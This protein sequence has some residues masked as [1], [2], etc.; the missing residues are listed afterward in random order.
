MESNA[1]TVEERSPALAVIR[2]TAGSQS[3]LAA[4]A[5]TDIFFSLASNGGSFGLGCMAGR[6]IVGTPAAGA[7]N[8]DQLYLAAND[9]GN[10][11]LLFRRPDGAGGTI[12]RASI[13]VVPPTPLVNNAPVARAGAD[14]QITEGAIFSLNGSASSDSD[15]YPL[16]FQWARTDAGSPGDFFVGSAEQTKPNPQ[17]QAPSLGA[18]PTPLTLTN[19]V[20]MQ[21]FSV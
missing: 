1:T 12:I 10:V 19:P 20:P 15:G 17:L 3:T 14:L 6:G 9:N 21:V 18:D 8:G 16:R 11:M 2:I 4:Q 13:L 5:G 7:A